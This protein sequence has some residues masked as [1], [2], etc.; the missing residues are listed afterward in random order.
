MKYLRCKYW[1]IE[2][3]KVQ[4]KE[5]VIVTFMLLLWLFSI[6]RW[7]NSCKIN[8]NL[9]IYPSD[10][11]VS[12]FGPTICYMENIIN[13]VCCFSIKILWFE[14]LANYFWFAAWFYLKISFVWH[15]LGGILLLCFQSA[16]K[17]VWKSNPAMLFNT[18][19][20]KAKMF[21]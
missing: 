17:V 15:L 9:Q 19:F 1:N 10:Q 21:V 2:I 18:F 4:P 5:V 7:R 6:Y 11:N 14:L 16:I 8:F 13:K 20:I 3:F 12:R